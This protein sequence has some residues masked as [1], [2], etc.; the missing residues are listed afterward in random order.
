[1]SDAARDLVSRDIVEI[2]TLV[3]GGDDYEILCTVADDRVVAFTQAAQRTGV[4]LSSIGM[5][6]AGSAVP[7]F[8]DR[9]GREVALKRRSYSHF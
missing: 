9:Q 7:K 1:L 5:V 6:V 3:A 4:A 2:E 8:L